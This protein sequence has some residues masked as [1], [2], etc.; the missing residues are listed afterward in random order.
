VKGTT[1]KMFRAASQ[2]EHP[3]TKNTH[4]T[5]RPNRC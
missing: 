3:N 4:R 1:P 2:A 5:T